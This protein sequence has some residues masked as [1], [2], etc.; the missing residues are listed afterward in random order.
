MKAYVGHK[1]PA[2]ALAVANTVEA[3]QLVSELASVMEALVGLVEQETA[4]VR[5]GGLREAAGLASRKTELAGQYLAATQRLKV[6]APLLMRELPEALADLSRQH[7]LF[8]ALLQINLT[9]L[10]TAHAVAEGIIRGA[11]NAV[12]RKT[13]PQA[14]GAAGRAIQ[15]SA[16]AA[17]PV[18]L[19][20]KF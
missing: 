20:Q 16:R 19:S 13:A 18:V 15:P 14:Y 7:D 6:S 12:A 4:L 10:A 5:E 8:H 11:V 1:V 17:A 3:Q 2:A 9:V